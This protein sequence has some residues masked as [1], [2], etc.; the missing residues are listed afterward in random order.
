VK[1]RTYARGGRLRF[2]ALAA[3][4]VMTSTAYAATTPGAQD[5]DSKG[6]T[7]AIAG[8]REQVAYGKRLELSGAVAER[9]N[10]RKVRLEHAPGGRGWRPVAARSTSHGGTWRFAVRAT[11]SGAY[12]AVSQSGGASAPRRVTVVARVAARAPRHVKRGAPVR[13]T[14]AVRPGVAGRRVAVELRSGR[15]WSTVARLRT[16]MGGR[17]VAAWRP[18]AHGRY[19]LRVRFRGDRLN[20]GDG[21][22]V[23]RVNVYRPAAA[24]WYGPGLYGNALG[25]GGRLGT[26]TLGVAHKTLPCGTKVTLRYG[27][28]S[29]TVPVV[30]RGPYVG[31]REFDLTGATKQRLGFGSTGTVWTTE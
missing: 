2:G 29:V 31:G 28:R 24:S 4:L 14:G 1:T 18:P 3:C 16:G 25:C 17:F 5:A 30:D 13:V 26:G 10:G 9:V 21:D 12:R 15:G 7:I 6:V 22:G 27:G 19:R 8:D 11:Q 23:G 20:A